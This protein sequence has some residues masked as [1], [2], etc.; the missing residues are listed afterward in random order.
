MNISGRV[1]S[2]Q[3]GLPRTFG[4]ADAADQADR[5]WTTGFFKEPITGRVRFHATHLEGDGQADHKNHGGI[6]KAVLG[7][8]AEHYPLWEAEFEQAKLEG[9]HLPHGGFG[10]NLTIADLTEDAVC[11]GDRWQFGEVQL[12]VSQPRQPCWKIGRR[13]R[14]PDLTKRVLQTGRTGWYFRIVREGLAEPG[15]LVLL[16]RPNPE[17]SIARCN[18]IFYAG[19]D[20]EQLGKLANIPQLAEVWQK[21]IRKKFP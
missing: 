5:L 21:D 9:D 16:K 11:I 18:M 15:D 8:S 13:W 1:V 19:T 10:E 17:W 7:Y 2:I 6:D 14:M 20:H 3:I 12:E 4:D